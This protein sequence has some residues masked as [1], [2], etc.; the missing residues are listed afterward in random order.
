MEDRIFKSVPELMR[1]NAQY[2][3][4]CREA[5]RKYFMLVCLIRD[6]QI[7]DMTEI[8]REGHYGVVDGDP[9]II[10]CEIIAGDTALRFPPSPDA[11]ADAKKRLQLAI[12]E[13]QRKGAELESVKKDLANERDYCVELLNKVGSMTQEIHRLKVVGH[14]KCEQPS[15]YSASNAEQNSGALK[16]WAGMQSRLDDVDERLAHLACSIANIGAETG[17]NTAAAEKWLPELRAEHAIV[18]RIWKYVEAHMGEA[19]KRLRIME[20]A[21][22]STGELLDHLR[23]TTSKRIEAVIEAHSQDM[24]NLWSWVTKTDTQETAPAS[25][26]KIQ[27]APLE[28]QVSGLHDAVDLLTKQGNS[29]RDLL[30]AVMNDLARMEPFLN[31]KA[32]MLA[33]QLRHAELFQVSVLRDRVAELAA[34][35][36]KD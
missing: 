29:M 4:Q 21:N 9:E 25:Q 3:R 35:I 23:D 31:N 15:P 7:P 36:D 19:E 14:G 10:K 22:A 34:K 12:A 26:P 1:K 24:K 16:H 5:A 17:A 2:E 6:G 30:Q 33:D 8:D 28:D 32:A 20:S 13:S 11:M 18:E 27:M